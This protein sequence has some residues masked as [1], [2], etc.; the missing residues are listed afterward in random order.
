MLL[1]LSAETWLEGRSAQGDLDFCLWEALFVETESD[2]EKR[3]ATGDS[4]DRP[5]GHL[6][7]GVMVSEMGPCYDMPKIPRSLWVVMV[8]SRQGCNDRHVD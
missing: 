8:V 6:R 3:A 4:I 2:G 1:G 7:G 5:Y